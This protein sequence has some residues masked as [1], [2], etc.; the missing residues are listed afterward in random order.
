MLRKSSKLLCARPK[1]HVLRR[2]CGLVPNFAPFV[3][4]L[5][6]TFARRRHLKTDVLKPL[7][8]YK[9]T[10]LILVIVALYIR[11]GRF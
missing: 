10:I 5:W 1:L 6:V 8:Y 4:A 2:A 7:R 11:D 3:S 9:T